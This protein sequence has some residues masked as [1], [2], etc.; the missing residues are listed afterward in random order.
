LIVHTDVVSEANDSNQLAIQ[1][2]CA[3]ANLGG[4]CRIAC[5]DS[6]Y[7]D[8]EEIAKMESARKTVVVPSQKQASHKGIDPF[9]KSTFP[10]DAEVDCYLCSEGNRLIF[11]RFQ[12]RTKQRRDYRIENPRICRSCR[13]SKQGRTVVRHVLEGLK[14][15]VAERLSQSEFRQIYERR[16]AR[17]EHPFGYIKKI[18]GFGQFLLRGREGVRAETSI[19][20]TCFNLTRMINLLGGVKGFIAGIQTV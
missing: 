8:I 5:A 10:Y 19:L 1:I 17:V 15:K 14:E 9:D 18:I 6:G 12:D 7:S 20:A 3:E 2:C 16:K 4:E 13:H 11:G